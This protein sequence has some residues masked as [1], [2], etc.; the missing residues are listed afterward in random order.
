MVNMENILQTVCA[1]YQ[2]RP[3]RIKGPMRGNART[4]EA[5][6]LVIYFSR[7]IPDITVREIAEYLGRDYSSICCA[8]KAI[9]RKMAEQEGFAARMGEIQMAMMEPEA[10]EG[11]PV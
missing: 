4:S 2:V 3:E 11:T 9:K 6:A 5:R 7:E 1:N 8:T 10:E